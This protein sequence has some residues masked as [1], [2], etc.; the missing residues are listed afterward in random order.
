MTFST[1]A[2]TDKGAVNGAL[3]VEI[4]AVDIY[5]APPVRSFYCSDKDPYKT[6]P[7][8]AITK[9]ILRISIV[10][11]RRRFPVISA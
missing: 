10:V 11:I 3:F 4:R 1:R 8:I 2:G 9:E 7:N 6:H 5:E